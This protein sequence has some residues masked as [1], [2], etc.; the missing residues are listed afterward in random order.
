MLNSRYGWVFRILMLCYIVPSG[1]LKGPY[2][3]LS[4]IFCCRVW[5]SDQSMFIWVTCV[6]SVIFASNKDFTFLNW[7]RFLCKGIQFL[8]SFSFL[9]FLNPGLVVGLLL[10]FQPDLLS[11]IQQ[12][13][14]FY[15]SWY[16]FSTILHFQCYQYCW[17]Q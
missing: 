16:V 3:H 9:G 7:I 17:F 15:I 14:S 12:S 4:I 10:P 6:A 2:N 5:F 13:I 8:F 11:L 1:C